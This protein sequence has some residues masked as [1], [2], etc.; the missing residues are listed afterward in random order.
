MKVLARVTRQEKEIKGIQIIKEEGKLSLFAD[1]MISY[2]E[3]HKDSTK[4]TW[5]ELINKAIKVAGY[6][7]NIQNLFLTLTMDYHKD[8]LRKQFCLQ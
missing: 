3:N 1:D 2:T 8:N 6:R 5:L 4:K 7:V